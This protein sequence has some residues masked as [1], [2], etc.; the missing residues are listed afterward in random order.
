MRTR[1]LSDKIRTDQ[2]KKV[3]LCHVWSGSDGQLL[4][5]TKNGHTRLLW[6]LVTTLP[7]TPNTRL[8]RCCATAP[9]SVSCSLRL[10]HNI[11]GAI[12]SVFTTKMSEYNCNPTDS[13]WALHPENNNKHGNHT[14]RES[15]SHNMNVWV[16][17]FS[18]EASGFLFYLQSP[19][20]HWLTSSLH[21]TRQ[22]GNTKHVFQSKQ[23]V[24]ETGLCFQIQ[25]T[26]CCV[27]WPRKNGFG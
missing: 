16:N 26:P 15:F 23:S 18:T 27:R 7:Q 8:H 4:R 11:Y 21:C 2:E 10:I 25:I 3:K 1:Q 9:S 5:E 19:H 13:W 20:Y 22:S 12:I 24:D 6:S 14:L 17:V